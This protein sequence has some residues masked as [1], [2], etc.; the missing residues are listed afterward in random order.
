MPVGISSGF[1][2]SDTCY[3]PGNLSVTVLMS[4]AVTGSQYRY[5]IFH[6]MAGKVQLQI[7][8]EEF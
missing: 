7:N 6:Y 4:A 5:A 2:F 1:P 8:S 3:S